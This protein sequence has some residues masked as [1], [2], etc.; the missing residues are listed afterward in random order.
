MKQFFLLSVLLFLFIGSNAQI[1]STANEKIIYCQIVG[2][3]FLNKV[4]VTIDMGEKTGFMRMNTSYIIDETT[5]KE[6]KFNSM[7]DAL[8]FMGEQGWELAQAYALGEK[9]S[10]TYH[11]LLKQRVLK[12][13]DGSYFPATKKVFSKS[14]RKNETKER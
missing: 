11:Y 14:D 13:D 9:G 5:G 10:Y 7:V 12:S 1:D 3:S 6:K 4:T 8:N 2:T